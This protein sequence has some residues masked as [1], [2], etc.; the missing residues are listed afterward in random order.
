MHNSTNLLPGSRWVKRSLLLGLLFG[1]GSQQAFALIQNNLDCT[2]GGWV[3][4]GTVDLGDLAPG[5]YFEV[6]MIGNCRVTR[7]F[8]Y[9]SSLQQTQVL[10][11]TPG[12]ALSMIATAVTGEVV[13]EQPWGVASSVCMP[14]NGSGCKPLPVNTS[15]VYNVMFSMP[16]GRGP[17][18]PGNY[19]ITL[20]LTS[21]SIKGY[22]GYVDLIQSLT[23]KYRIVNP[24][25][26]MSSGTALNLPFGTLNSNDFAT[27]QQLANITLNCTRGTQATAT[28]IPTQSAVSGRP[29]VSATTLAGLSMATTWADNNTAVTFNSPRTLNLTTGTNTIRLGFRPSL[30]TS[31]SPTGSFTSQYTLNINYL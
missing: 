5:E 18:T 2:P 26:S 29:G 28:L 4:G 8:P 27:S 16:K 11:Q 23:L 22:E 7:N 3:V 31:A 14:T 17:T 15:N 20:N 12:P 1:L 6:R 19:T 10:T 9:G 21:T 13:P 30:N 25:C 24:A